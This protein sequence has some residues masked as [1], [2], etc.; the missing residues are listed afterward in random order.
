M[1]MVV[2]LLRDPNAGVRL[3]AMS[4]LEKK[5]ELHTI[6]AHAPVIAEFLTGLD[7]DMR[8]SAFQTLRKLEQH[9]IE[10]YVPVIVRCVDDPDSSVGFEAMRTLCQLGPR[11]IETC[12][13][14]IVPQLHPGGRFWY[15]AL[16]CMEKLEPHALEPH[17]ALIAACC[18][19]KQYI[20]KVDSAFALFGN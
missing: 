15:V 13:S 20:M 4:T 11:V 7:T 1:T 12:L 5:F 2:D 3:Q 18:Q 19:D 6:S 14:V 10:K 9:D 16:K 17:A 8:L